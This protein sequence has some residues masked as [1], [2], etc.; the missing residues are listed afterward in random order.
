MPKDREPCPQCQAR[1]ANRAR[2]KRHT[3][4]Y[5]FQ[6]WQHTVKNKG[7]RIKKSTIKGAGEGLFAEKTFPAHSRVIQYTGEKLTNS[8]LNK[9][10]PGDK[11]GEYTVKVNKQY[12][13][14]ARNSAKSS[15]ARYANDARGPPGSVTQKHK[16][17]DLAHQRIGKKKNTPR[18][19]VYIEAN[20]R[21]ISK[22][23]EV[24]VDYG[25]DYWGATKPVRK[26]TKSK[27]KSAK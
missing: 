13:I 4:K 10:Y 11:Q 18:D 7:L 21:P 25:R 5:G 12:S 17:A 16:N 2:C 27:S 24:L 1:A 20:N 8:Q 9:R 23:Q 19:R 15:V 6:C 22:G 26:T 3:C 14:D